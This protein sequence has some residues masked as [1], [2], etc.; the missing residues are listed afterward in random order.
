VNDPVASQVEQL[1]RERLR[2][3]CSGD[4]AAFEAP[5]MAQNNVSRWCS[6]GNMGSTLRIAAPSAVELIDYRQLRDT[7]GAALISS[8]SMALVA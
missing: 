8:A 5:F 2:L 4:A 7:N 1:D 6:L 3:F